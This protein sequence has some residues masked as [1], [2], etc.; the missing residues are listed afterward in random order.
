MLDAVET[1]VAS[2]QA[3]AA[4][5]RAKAKNA[6]AE[7]TAALA[8]QA[9][10]SERQV[11]LSRAEEELARAELELLRAAAAGKAAAEKKRTAANAAVTAARKTLASAPGAYT[12][13]QGARKTP[14]SNLETGAS[15]TR[16]FPKTST[17]RRSAL[18]QWITDRRNP[19]TARVAVNHVW[20]RHFGKPL[21]ETVFDLGRK[22]SPPSHPALLDW[23]AVEF[24]ENGWSLKH[25][26]RLMV[27][28]DAYRLAS[29][30]A[31]APAK[32]RES[33]AENRYYWRMNPM[34]MEAQVLRDSLLFLA[35][36]L[37]LKLG[38]PAIPIQDEAS[39]RR[40]LYFV[41]SHNEQQKFL[42]IFDDAPVLECYRRSVS[43]VPQQALALANSKLALTMAGRINDRLHQQFG[44]GTDRDFARAAFET[45]LAATPTAEELTVCEEALRQWQELAKGRPDAVRRARGNLIHALL[46]HNDFITIR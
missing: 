41:H 27:T 33:D 10:I 16:P 45:V 7:E 20:M 24:M 21:V 1:Q 19:L 25:L 18:A 32:N 35:G 5:D 3:R 29:S 17:G 36:E 23:L 11:A 2:F 37:D 30:N 14:E 38:G 40:S 42:G 4:A 13:L 46:N 8:R 34:R 26:H 31:G 28:S 43:I 9:A 15:L 12:P 39:R 6:P 22:G 44:Q